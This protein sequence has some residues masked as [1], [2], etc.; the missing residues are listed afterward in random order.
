MSVSPEFQPGS[1][2]LVGTPIGNLGDISRRMQHALEDC[3]IVIAEDTRR[4]RRLLSHLGIQGKKV[5]A[6]DANKERSSVASVVTLVQSGNKVVYCSDAGMP[7]ISDPGTVLVSEVAFA[8]LDVDAIPGPSAVV[9]SASLSGL[10]EAGF[11]FSGFLPNKKGP[12][13]KELVRLRDNGF[14]CIVFESP[15]RI[16]DLLVDAC[17][18]FG[19]NHDVFIGRELTKIHQELF[20]GSVSQALAHFSLGENR[21][22]FVAVFGKST[23]IKDASEVSTLVEQ[24]VSALKN[25]SHGTKEAAAEIAS[26]TGLPKGRVY[27]ILLESKSNGD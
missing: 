12:R 15:N 13:K 9:V 6:I 4:V 19:V 3:D 16:C 21:G 5:I 18:I 27:E 17:E 1:F 26:V 24:I 8:G 14:A 7:G 22:E 10:C 2:T 11:T 20:Y 25:G 23:L